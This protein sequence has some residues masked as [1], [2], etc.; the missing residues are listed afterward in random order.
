MKYKLV[1]LDRDGVINKKAPRHEY[2][3]SWR[4]FKFLPKAK[5]AIALLSQAGHKIVVIT[6]QRGIGRGMLSLE[7][8]TEITKKM[9]E[10]IEK[11]RGRINAVYFCPHDKECNCRKPKP[12]LVLQALKDSSINANE[13]IFLGDSFADYETAKNAGCDFMNINT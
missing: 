5:E 13:A 4:Q 1:I 3:T 12:G 11:S 6:N 2:V 8:F 9:T 10:E 7:V